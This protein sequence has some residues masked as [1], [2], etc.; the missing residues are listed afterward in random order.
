[1]LNMLGIPPL[2]QTN[3][4]LRG[5]KSSL[6]INKCNYHFFGFIFKPIQCSTC[7]GHNLQKKKGIVKPYKRERG[8]TIPKYSWNYIK[9]YGMTK[10]YNRKHTILRYNTSLLNGGY[11]PKPGVPFAAAET[12]SIRTRCTCFVHNR[13]HI[14]I[15]IENMW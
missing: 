14:V 13:T 8:K 2:H 11:L 5:Y 1:M 7:N 15:N 3:K 9:K 6:H 10:R 4:V 12:I